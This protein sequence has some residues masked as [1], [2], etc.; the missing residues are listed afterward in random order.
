MSDVKKYDCE[1]IVR[2]KGEASD[3][4]DR[5]TGVLRSREEMEKSLEVVFFPLRINVEIVK[6]EIEDA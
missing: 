5:A 1:Y 4:A 6:T 2:L 3:Y